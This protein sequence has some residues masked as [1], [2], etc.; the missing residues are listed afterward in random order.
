MIGSIY[1]RGVLGVADTKAIANVIKR[2]GFKLGVQRFVAGETLPEA[3]GVLRSLEQ[4]GFHGILD[5]LGEFV[6]T[7][8]GALAITDEILQTLDVL[9]NEQ[10]DRY[11]SIKPTQL[12]LS[13]GYTFA[14]DNARRA[15]K[16]AQEIGAHICLDMESAA[17]VDG[18]LQMLNTLH[19]E[20]FTNVSTV[21][22]SYLYRTMDD[23]KMLLAR[24][25]TQ[26]LRI[27]KGAYRESPAVAYPDKRDVDANYRAL[28]RYGFE[29]GA[30]V[31]IAT[32]DDSIIEEFETYIRHHTI[33][34]SRY[35]YQ[36]LYGV[37]PNLQKS[38]VARG[39]PVR[40]YIPY[41]Q[42]WYGYFTRRLAERPANMMFVVKG[43]FG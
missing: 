22:Q 23:L 36:F 19:G 28:V 18:T 9:S 41:G 32:H 21:L 33:D 34:P 29:Q 4:Q 7:E 15:V 8:A 16:R 2:Q 25:P 40:I 11:M 43:L 27:V 20:G 3:L 31:N 42:D 10:L 26:T 6:D 1:R 17:Y 37:K 12:G 13:V 38:L 5:L 14:L 30:K 39:H 35:E 24:E